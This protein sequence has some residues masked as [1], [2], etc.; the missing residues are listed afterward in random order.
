VS[1]WKVTY[2]Q[3]QQEKYWM[4]KLPEHTLEIGKISKPE[5]RSNEVSA[6]LSAL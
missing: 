2:L 4:S 1:G 3:R 5:Y 6:L